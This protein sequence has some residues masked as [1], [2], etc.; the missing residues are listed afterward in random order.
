MSARD[1][2]VFADVDL[3][4]FDLDNTL[5]PRPEGLWAQ[6]H[7][8]MQR[9]I[10]ENVGL[11]REAAAAMQS[12]YFQKY[13]LTM[14][15]LM[16]HH[17][18]E[19]D[20]FNDYVHDVDLSEIAPNPALGEAIAAL[21]GR[22]IIH[23]NATL[24]HVGKVLARLGIAHAFDEAYDIVTSR[25]TPKPAES[26]YRRVLEETGGEPSRAAMFED[27]A[28][29]LKVPH[30]LG[31]RCVHVPTACDWAS[32]GAGEDHIHFVAEDLTAFVRDVAEM[33]SAA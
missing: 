7:E 20:A 15:G 29:N 21:P 14:R 31:M 28:H 8:R 19:P 12:D 18:V 33:R 1:L 27:I 3:W 5:Y 6:V 26:S 24:G 16:L 25:Y 11:D 2:T 32:L 13:G 30:A 10:M 17:G 22:R 4:I 23:S 9:F